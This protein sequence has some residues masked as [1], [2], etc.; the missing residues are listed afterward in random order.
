[1][2]DGEKESTKSEEKKNRRKREENGRGEEQQQRRRNGKM[3]REEE[4]NNQM[5]EFKKRKDEKK[6]DWIMRRGEGRNLK[7]IKESEKKVLESSVVPGI[8]RFC[9]ELYFLEKLFFE[10][11]LSTIMF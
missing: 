8:I 9:R 10:L 4:I 3:K 1:M 5:N 6:D 2:E 11:F 7:R